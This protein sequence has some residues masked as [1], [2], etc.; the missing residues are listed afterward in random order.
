MIHIKGH[1][2]YLREIAHRVMKERGLLPD[3]N[4]ED[5]RELAAIQ[6]S[7]VMPNKTVRDMRRQIW[8]SIDN[9]NSRD[10]DQLTYAEEKPNGSVR[11]YVAL[12]DVD[13]LVKPNTALD[14]HAHH[15][16][17]TVYTAAEVFPMLPEKLS[18][19][20]T[21]LG[22]GAERLALVVEMQVNKNGAITGFNIYRAWVRNYAKLS[23]R[24]LA[25]WL[26]GK[27]VMPHAVGLIKG[28]DKNL[29]LQDTVAQKMKNLRHK[30]GALEF[31]TIHASPVFEGEV[32]TN[33]V[34]DRS[35]RAKD[36]VSDF[37]IATNGVVARYLNSQNYPSLRRVVRTPQRW[38]RIVE[39]ALE[40]G[41]KL[42]QEP[43]A[44][45]LNVF[46]TAEKAAD[47]LRFPDLSL[48]VIKLLGGGEYTVEQP[49]GNEE[50]HFGLAVKDYTHSTAP[51]RRYPD[52]I[53]HR[54]VKAALTGVPVPYT[55]DELTGLAKHCTQTEDIVKKVER[56]VNKSAAALLLHSRIGEEFDAIVT[57][58]SPKGTWVRLL[59]LPVEGR[60]I[61]GSEGL[62]I[63][64]KVQVQL[65]STDVE[66]GFIDLKRVV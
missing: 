41:T 47:S 8:C 22:L 19:N 35:N 33:L 54:L 37:M 30:R 45:A 15:N 2:T 12:A 17:C 61:S 58:A 34:Q 38:D 53:T 49:G 44:I 52:L 36:I 27:A 62:D 13:A 14:K 24:N 43:D 28:L 21:S 6:G 59:H 5:L 25:E 26:D 63:G 7:A 42:P 29:R 31:E 20:L 10:L 48:S 56:Q 18:T 65:V 11:I 4:A 9:D 66:K 23:Y 3:F 50:G 60:L 57:G 32:L 51:N 46:L 39:L 1:H 64:H 40:L 55:T 16:T